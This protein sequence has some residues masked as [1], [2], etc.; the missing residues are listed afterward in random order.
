MVTGHVGRFGKDPSATSPE[1]NVDWQL[2]AVSDQV[3]GVRLSVGEST[4]TGWTTSRTTVWYDRVEK[5]AMDS[6]GL[7]KDRSAL[8]ALAALA[9]VELA[10]RS[11]VVDVD[12]VKAGEELFDSLSFNRDGDLVVEFDD[13]QVAAGSLGRVAVAVPE[14]KVAG[15]LSPTGVRA[16]SAAV[17]ARKNRAQVPS[18]ADIEAAAADR[19][20]RGAPGRTPWTARAP[21]AWH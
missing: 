8:N 11:Q 20:R 4:G 7:L 14:E 5:R 19:P 1:L 12:A 2:A 6:T 9:R 3:I 10:G 16:R 13:Y 21:S 18:A 17:T 15:L